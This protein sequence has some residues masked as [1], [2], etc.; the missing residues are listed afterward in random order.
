MPAAPTTSPSCCSASGDAMENG[1]GVPASYVL[2]TELRVEAAAA[3][4]AGQR[5]TNADAYVIDEA[6]GL[7]AVGDGM[8]DTPRSGLVARMAL[9]AV[10]EM[11]LPPWSILPAAD[12]SPAEAAERMY[13]GVLQAHRRITRRGEARISGS[14]RRSPESWFAAAACSAWGMS[15]T[16]GCTCSRGAAAGFGA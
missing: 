14:E 1:E 16:R 7:F 6:A 3:T 4:H 13:L 12:R 9:D 5:D 8:G 2:S 11:F 15:A 10:R